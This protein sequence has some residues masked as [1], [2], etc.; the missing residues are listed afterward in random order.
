MRAMTKNERRI[1]SESGN[2]YPS[3]M[4]NFPGVE[5]NMQNRKELADRYVSNCLS[6]GKIPYTDYIPNINKMCDWKGGATV[7]DISCWILLKFKGKKLADLMEVEDEKIYYLQ[8]IIADRKKSELYKALNGKNFLMLLDKYSSRNL[9]SSTIHN[10]LDSILNKLIAKSE[11][12]IIWID[13]KETVIGD[14]C[15]VMRALADNASAYS[16]DTFTEIRNII[17]KIHYKKGLINKKYERLDENITSRIENEYVK[18]ISRYLINKMKL[19]DETLFLNNSDK[20]SSTIKDISPD[21]IKDISYH[22]GTYYLYLWQKYGNSF[23]IFKF[24]VVNLALCNDSFK[25][26]EIIIKFQDDTKIL[27]E[28]LRIKE[29]ESSFRQKMLQKIENTISDCNILEYLNYFE[30]LIFN[31]EDISIIHRAVNMCK[32]NCSLEELL[33]LLN[34]KKLTEDEFD[35]PARKRVRSEMT[36]AFLAKIKKVDTNERKRCLSLYENMLLGLL[37]KLDSDNED[38]TLTAGLCVNLIIYSTR[39][40]IGSYITHKRGAI[41]RYISER[42]DSCFAQIN[43]PAYADSIKENIIC[44]LA[45]LND[46]DL[47]TDFSPASLV[48]TLL[49]NNTDIN[50]FKGIFNKEYRAVNIETEIFNA[51]LSYDATAFMKETVYQNYRPVIYHFLR[52]STKEALCMRLFDLV[53]GL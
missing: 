6:D 9:E 17:D 40:D 26:N 8:Q 43:D 49:R 47:S 23:P 50:D 41:L 27:F 5:S 29:F 10:W 20:I 25:I 44:L 31:E 39:S 32:E 24:L 18:C 3:F 28:L 35:G 33:Q 53:E 45:E 21:K 51:L 30:N 46:G 36:G 2:I 42:M 37:Q 16:L 15:T 48:F 22:L 14:I 12:E 7:D 52:H 38:E 4:V 13:S 19:K 11:Q 34:N 1:N